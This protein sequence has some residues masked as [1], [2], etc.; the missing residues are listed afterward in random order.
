[1]FLKLE[2]RV[3]LFFDALVSICNR[4]RRETDWTLTSFRGTRGGPAAI[5]LDLVPGC[6]RRLAAVSIWVCS[7]CCA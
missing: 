3:K 5:S 6:M 4:L 2:G 1:M 7:I